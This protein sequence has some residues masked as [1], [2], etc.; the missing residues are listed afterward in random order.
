[1][2]SRG[3]LGGSLPAEDTCPSSRLA[4]LEK[5]RA[6]KAAGGRDIGLTLEEK[7]CDKDPQCGGGMCCAVSIWVKSIRICTPMGKV[8]DSCHP[9]TRKVPFF[10]RRMHHTCPCM[11]GLACSRTSFNRFVCLARK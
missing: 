5:C 11:P 6:P 1:M 10:G 8:G 7:A 9:M 2:G 4:H 3:A